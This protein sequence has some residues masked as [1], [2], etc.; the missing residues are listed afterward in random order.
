M[1]G[2]A[3]ES[4]VIT[5]SDFLVTFICIKLNFAFADE[6]QMLWCISCTLKWSVFNDGCHCGHSDVAALHDSL[7]A[8]IV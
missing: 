5:K 3:E 7:L 1:V 4:L 2:V 8:R 6:H